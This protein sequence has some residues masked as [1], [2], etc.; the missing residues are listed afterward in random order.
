M[1]M[2]FKWEVKRELEEERDAHMH[3]GYCDV[4]AKLHVFST[5]SVV[6]WNAFS[7]TAIHI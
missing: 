2:A 4:F 6:W 7:L 5:V 1:M 3:N